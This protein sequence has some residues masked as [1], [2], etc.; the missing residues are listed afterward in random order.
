MQ[1]TKQRTHAAPEREMTAKENRD[2]AAPAEVAKTKFH[3][4]IDSVSAS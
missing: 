2:N 1:R 3:S 4:A